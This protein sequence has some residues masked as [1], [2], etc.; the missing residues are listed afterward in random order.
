MTDKTRTIW[1]V[2]PGERI[3]LDGGRVLVDVLEKSG[4]VARLRV[5][6]PREVKIQR[7]ECDGDSNS[8]R[9]YCIGG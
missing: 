3:S 5:T 9:A 8:Q 7:E 1:E 2:R 4:K 6:A